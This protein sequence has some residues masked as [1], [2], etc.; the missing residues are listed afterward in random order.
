MLEIKFRRTS[1]T[2]GLKTAY[3]VLFKIEIVALLV[4]S[5]SSLILYTHDIQ[6]GFALFFINSVMTT[7]MEDTQ[8][9][10]AFNTAQ[11]S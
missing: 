7:N 5:T 1:L 11:F 3:E 8:L 4:F 6:V 2:Q 10:M 9:N